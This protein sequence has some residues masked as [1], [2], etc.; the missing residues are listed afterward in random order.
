LSPRYDYLCKTGHWFEAVKGL[1]A[2]WIPCPEHG[3]PSRRADVSGIP[4]TVTETVPPKVS[5][6]IVR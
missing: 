1:G 6:E 3:E 4:G 2:R 5:K